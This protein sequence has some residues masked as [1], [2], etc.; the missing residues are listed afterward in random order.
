[1]LEIHSIVDCLKYNG[2][3]FLLIALYYTKNAYVIK[4]LMIFKIIYYKLILAV[5]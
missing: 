4:F 5:F 2:N 1:M 3:F